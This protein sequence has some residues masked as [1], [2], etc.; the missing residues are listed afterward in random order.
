MQAEVK[1]RS[2]DEPITLTAISLLIIPAITFCL[3]CWQVKRLKWKLGLIES[4]RKAL[5]EDPS[6]PMVELRNEHLTYA[7]TWFF[8]SAFTLGMWLSKFTRIRMVIREFRK[9][10]K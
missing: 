4:Q 8:L 3:G 1:P 10:N 9:R 7:I 6:R 5:E 2:L